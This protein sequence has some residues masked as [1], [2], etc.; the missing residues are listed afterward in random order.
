MVEIKKLIVN[1]N[2]SALGEGKLKLREG[3]LKLWDEIIW[4]QGRY[5]ESKLKSF[6][7]KLKLILA[8]PSA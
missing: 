2:Q 6:G 3:K 5:I 8:Y 1:W 7:G 4:F